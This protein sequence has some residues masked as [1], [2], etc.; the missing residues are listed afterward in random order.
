MQTD[1]TTLGAPIM[2]L[3]LLS[4]F[5][6]CFYGYLAK[7]LLVSLRSV[8]SGALVSLALALVFRGGV[9]TVEALEAEQ[10]IAALWALL[11]NPN[12]Y[13]N[14][15]I[16]LIS[17]SL[18]AL[19]LFL[20][21]RK[22]NKVLKP[23]VA[24]FTA[25]SMGLIIFLLMLSF[26][27]YTLSLVISLVLLVVILAFSLIRFDSYM[28]LESAIAGSLLIAYLLSRFW[29]LGFW[30]FFALWAVLAFLGII[31]QLHMVSRRAQIQESQNG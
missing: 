20:C 19:L 24:L 1:A 22:Q 26:L 21:A 9:Q 17:F 31:N 8:V 23:V 14:T 27:P 15:L 29:F 7:H 12:D 25:L 13:L 2:L 10:P 3:G 30:V 11:F 4:G 28:A 16:Y 5:F 6:L 18:G